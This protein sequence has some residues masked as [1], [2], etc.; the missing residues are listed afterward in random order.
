MK[1]LLRI[2]A[3]VLVLTPMSAYSAAPPALPGDSVYQLPATLMDAAGRTVAWKD[4]RG[5]PRVATMFYTSCKYICPLVVDSLRAVERKLTPAERAR[6]GFVL[7]SMDPER[8]TPEALSQLVA[9]RKLDPARWTLLQPNADDLRGIAGLLGIRYRSLADGE[10]NHS[11]AL[12]LLDAEGRVLARSEQ[13]GADGDPAFLGAVRA[14]ASG[15]A[16]GR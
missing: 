16:S 11:T 9:E 4:L 13:L 6:A 8:D 7:I 15:N 3:A 2:L 12:V 1:R 14:A 5:T 10:F